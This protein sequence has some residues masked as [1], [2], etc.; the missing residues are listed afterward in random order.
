MIVILSIAFEGYDK[1]RKTLYRT[2]LS[3]QLSFSYIDL[4]RLTYGSFG[5]VEVYMNGQWGTVCDD[6]WDSNDANVVCRQLGYSN[7][8]NA[9]KRAQYG[10]GTGTI[11]LDDVDCTGSESS[12]F[13]CA[14]T[15]QHDCS[16]S[17]DAGVSCS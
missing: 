13:D 2:H 3:L 17:E 1:T 12:I 8:A 9:Y 6:L 14:F 16:H 4:V 11:W 10:Q 15:T 5:R 7:A